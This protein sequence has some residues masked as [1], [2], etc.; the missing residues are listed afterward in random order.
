MIKR[1]KNSGSFK[2]GFTPWN[3]GK[4]LSLTHRDNLRLSHLGLKQ[5]EETIRKRIKHFT[6]KKHWTWKE[7]PSYYSIHQWIKRKNGKATLCEMPGCKYPRLGDKNKLLKEPKRYE[8]SCKNGKYRR[9]QSDWWQLCPSCH[10]KYDHNN[11]K[12]NKTNV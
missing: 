5:T 3:K 9:R 8:W 12:N 1:I 4:K 10:R 11:K 7:R 6:G 2:R